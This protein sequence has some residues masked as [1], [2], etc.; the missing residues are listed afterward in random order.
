MGHI[1]QI[2]VTHRFFSSLVLLVLHLCSV[3][4]LYLTILGLQGI[5]VKEITIDPHNVLFDDKKGNIVFELCI[6]S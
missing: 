1:T 2:V 3:M 5:S 6:N 4:G